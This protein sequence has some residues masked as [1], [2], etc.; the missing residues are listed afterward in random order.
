MYRPEEMAL[1][2]RR[3][4]ALLVIPAIPPALGGFPKTLGS[5]KLLRG[6]ETAWA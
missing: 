4:V 5:P 3:H 2:L 1:P 6:V